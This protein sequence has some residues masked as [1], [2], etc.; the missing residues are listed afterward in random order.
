MVVGLNLCPFAAP[1][2]RNNSIRYAKTEADNLEA[3]LGDFL[4][5]LDRIQCAEEEAL[6]T[7]LLML[8]RIA[9][10]FDDFLEIL[11]LCQALLEQTG[12]EGVFQLASFHP[13]YCFADVDEQH[14]SNWTNRAP[15]PTI[16][17]IREG[18]MARV[19]THYKNPEEIPERNMALMQQL[20]R[21]GLIQRFPPFADY[22]PNPDQ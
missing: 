2:V 18:Q 19:L 8:T 13:Q 20:G 6:S 3:V 15:F 22:W 1:E 12:L 21:E 9:E 16:H 4:H 5:E 7:T 17:I 14:I 10:S 11:D